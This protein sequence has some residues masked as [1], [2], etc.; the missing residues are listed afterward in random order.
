[1]LSVQELPKSTDDQQVGV[2]VQVLLNDL[3]SAAFYVNSFPYSQYI[4]T[5]LVFDSVQRA[6]DCD[7]KCE[8][9]SIVI[10][11]CSI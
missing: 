4:S 11:L 10:C 6:V 9:T 7:L 1:M 3:N 8:L 2:L 5:I